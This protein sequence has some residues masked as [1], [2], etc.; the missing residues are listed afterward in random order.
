LRQGYDQ[1]QTSLSGRREIPFDDDDIYRAG[2]TL[3]TSLDP[4]EYDYDEADEI[5]TVLTH[6]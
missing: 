3:V 2:G 6:K 5:A 4:S 1:N